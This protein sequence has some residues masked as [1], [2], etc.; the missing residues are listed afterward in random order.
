MAALVASMNEV[1]NLTMRCYGD[2]PSTDPSNI[3]ISIDLVEATR[4]EWLFLRC[5]D[6]QWRVL[7]EQEVLKNA[8]RRYE[9]VWLPL[10]VRTPCERW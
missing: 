4:N 6:S 3:R 10:L 8:V 5:I 9:H 1:N 2:A 7:Y